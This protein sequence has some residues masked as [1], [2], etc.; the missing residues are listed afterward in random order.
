MLNTLG[1]LLLRLL[2]AL[3][4][5]ILAAIGNGLGLLLYAIG[6]ERRRV[7]RINLRLCFPDMPERQRE[8]LVRRHFQAFARSFLE[9][10]LC[11]WA[12]PARLRRLIQVRGQEHLNAEAGRPVILMVPHF[13]ALDMAGCV[14]NMDYAQVSIYSRQK[15]IAYDDAMLKGR[16]R[17][18]KLLLFSRQDGIRPVVRGLK[19]GRVF[20][21]LPDQ[22]YGAKDALFAPFFGVP[23]ATITGLSRIAR[24][25]GARVL[26]CF[27]RALPYGQGYQVDIGPAWPDFPSDDLARDTR[28]M[29]AA[30]E[31]AVLTMPEQYFWLHKRFKT[32][33]EGEPG[34][35]GKHTR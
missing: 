19:E 1:L 28:R 12:S 2:A 24:L 13:V 9:R 17:F 32:R 30:I 11:W 31:A 6:R 27:A 5:P 20:F 29:N 15:N 10:G 33:P 7:A 14:M 23:A 22:D 18:G 26:S 21:Y 8:R 3:P 4:L 16:L 25:S 35:Y 34:F